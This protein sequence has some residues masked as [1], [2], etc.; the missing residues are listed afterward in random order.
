MAT[1]IEE[2]L[3]SRLKTDTPITALVSNRIYPNILPQNV[4]YPAISYMR[5]T[6]PRIHSHSGSS[7]LAHPLFQVD[8]WATTYSGVKDLAEKV[9][10]RLQGFSGTVV[11]VVINGILF[12]GDRDS[13][14]DEVEV[15]RVISEYRVW[16]AEA[17][18]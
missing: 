17:R 6:G 11:T 8:Q 3:Y 1:T 2:A 9:R 10:L 7:G 5:V 14:D 16:H 4:A 12:V 15:F 13:Y 18:P